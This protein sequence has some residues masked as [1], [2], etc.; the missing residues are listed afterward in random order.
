M[1]NLKQSEVLAKSEPQ[2]SLKKHIEDGLLIWKEL[3]KAFSGL[4]V[5]DVDYFWEILRTSVICHDLGKAHK[6]FQKLLR[7]QPNNWYGQ[8]H[9]L[10]S[11]PFIDG[12]DFPD[13]NK[14]LIKQIVAG[15]H[16]TYSELNNFIT[17]NYQQKKANSFLLTFD[18]DDLLSFQSEFEKCLNNEIYSLLN[19]YELEFTKQK[20]DLPKNLII[21]Y[22]RNPVQLENK[23]Y[24]FLLLLTGAFKQCDHLSSASISQI[25]SLFSKDFDFLSAKH[26]LLKEKGFDFYEHQKEASLTIGNVI[27]TAPTGSGK[28]ESSM[29]WLKKQL[30]EKGQG[31]V[32]YILPF[33]ASINAMYERLSKDMQKGS[34][35]VIHGKLASYLDNL[36]ERE[37]PDI[38]KQQRDYLLRQL[39][40]D[41]QTL[42]TP[43]KIATPFQLLK[44]IFGLKGF[45]KGLFEMAGGY[46]IFDEI[47]AYNPNVFAQIIVLI[48]FAVRYLKVNV[49][50][51]TATLPQFLKIELQKAIGSY[52]EITAK[53]ELYTLFTRHKIVLKEGLLSENLNIIQDDL[54]AD[55]KVLVVCNTVEQA[56][57]V[58]NNLCSKNKVLLHG[59]FNAYDRNNK[60]KELKK[61]NINLLVGTQAIEVS[62]DID[63]DIIYTEPAPIDALIQRFGR[64]NRKRKKG[65]SPCVVFKQRNDSD[66]YIY[67][68]K[69]VIIRTLEVLSKFSTQIEEEKLQEA[70]DYVYPDWSD[71]DKNDFILTRDLLRD[72]LRRLSP[73]MH[74]D[75]SEE[76]FYKQFDGIKVLPAIC[77][78]KYKNLL[79]QFEFIKAESLKVQIRKSRFAGL[80]NSGD[81]IKQRHICESSNTE[82]LIQTDYFV[83]NRKY[84]TDLGLM[85]KEAED[86]EII[87]NFDNI[88]L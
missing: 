52:A 7:K 29:L 30:E 77:E 3:K 78:Q 73:F 44:H 41:F 87:N 75:K 50:V 26:K 59:S 32:F 27:L 37:N 88:A 49:F 28:T 83:I 74:S 20:A 42:V 1:N 51:M 71:K 76:D 6:E 62:L 58:Y 9:E 8:R 43:L 54:N 21:D 46:F 14:I 13:E 11:I 55:K 57:F 2:V 79:N 81:I 67:Q 56:Q 25:N 31:R 60:E 84:T 66:K 85:I 24:L 12:L 53:S 4:P 5:K 34:V 22:L 16:K 69:N 61:E 48:E 68:D 33:T 18:E 38:S 36:I 10:F 80:I 45:E 86:K 72:Y 15:H 65:I 17:H 35:G 39:K 47:H 40:D 70:I 23:N 63:Y 64:V 82:K 19:S